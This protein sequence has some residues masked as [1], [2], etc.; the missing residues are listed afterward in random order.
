[1]AP[2][3]EKD[4]DFPPTPPQAKSTI[5]SL[6]DKVGV[7]LTTSPSIYNPPLPADGPGAADF[8]NGLLISLLVGAPTF[9]AWKLGGGL[10]T[11]IFFFLLTAIPILI[12]FWT[13]TSNFSPRVNDKVK[14]PGRPLDFYLTFK[15]PADKARYGVRGAKIAQETFQEMYFNGDVEV[16]GDM[17]EVLEYRHDWTTFNFTVNTFKFLF[18]TFF[19]DVIFHTRAQD[20]DQV[21][22]T[23]DRGNDFYAWFLGPRMIY[24]SGIISDPTREETLEEMQDNKLSVVMEKIGLKEGDRLLDI[25]CGW[26]TL[27]RFASVNYGAKVT[28][29]TLA[30]EQVAWGNAGLRAAGVPE[31]QSRLLC[32]DYRDIPNAEKFDKITALE[33]AEHV[34]VRRMVTFWRQVSDHLVDDGVLYVQVSGLRKAWQYED[35]IWGL[36]MNK[37]IF[38]GADASTPLGPYVDQLEAAGF[39]IKSVD[40]IGVH[41]SATL[42]RWYRNWLGNKDKVKAK[43]GDKWYRIWEYFLA[44]STIASR[45]GSATCFQ[46]VCVKN[47]NSTHR[48]EGVPTQYGLSGAL[49]AAKAA[50]KS[51]LQPL[52]K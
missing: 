42:W 24:T 20:E 11:T 14:L 43:Y 27:T 33:M 32:C 21:R 23:Y 40:T 52:K 13:F 26:G 35:F 5:E 18:F 37:Y 15:N 47:L 46:I 44:S 39:E 48:I 16:N 49:A 6:G 19:P 30:R 8:S 28:G 1:M 9:L 31:E 29:V 50:G 34:G 12:A 22:D 2:L 38:P 36:F 4:V 45:Q 25:G 10:K 7:K 17:L 41:Y 51:I 3:T